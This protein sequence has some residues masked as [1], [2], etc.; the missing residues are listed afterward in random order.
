M[1]EGPEEGLTDN[2]LLHIA[3]L[4]VLRPPEV[5][6]RFGLSTGCNKT[7]LRYLVW[8]CGSLHLLAWYGNLHSL[9]GV[10]TRSFGVGIC[11]R[12]FGVGV[13][14]R[15]VWECV[16]VGE[17]LHLFGVGAIEELSRLLRGF[18]GEQLQGRASALCTQRLP[19]TGHLRSCSNNYVCLQP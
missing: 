3:L 6:R 15:L 7:F 5:L 12:S 17:S 13:C 11:T 1:Q 16:L 14:T 19:A 2:L 18:G 4:S 9:G 10:C 8:W